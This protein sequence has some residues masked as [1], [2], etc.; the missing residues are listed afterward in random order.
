[1][2]KPRIAFFLPGL[3]IVNRGAENF[4]LELSKRLKKNYGITFLSKGRVSEN[5]ISVKGISRNNKMLCFI[6]KLPIIRTALKLFLLDPINIEWLTSSFNTFPK[7]FRTDFDLII[8]EAGMWGNLICRII[9]RF[10]HTPFVDVG[11]SRFGYW[12]YLCALQSPD[13]YVSLTHS[14]QKILKKRVKK[15]NSVV[16][17]GGVDLR[18]Y[19][20]DV[21]PVDLKLPKPIFLC[22]GALD[23]VK[24]THLA[25]HAVSK[26]KK[27]SL[28][29]LG[30]G[31]SRK[32]I[33][34]LG[35]RLLGKRFLLAA[36][37]SSQMPGY[38]AACDVFT[39]PSAR[40]SFGIIYA[41]AMAC[42]KPVVTT[43]DDIRMEIIGDAGI[44]C[45][46]ENIEEYSQALETAVH[47]NFGMRPRRQA[48]KHDWDGVAKKY[49]EL[50][51]SI[52]KREGYR[53]VL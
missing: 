23:P 43:R 5:W 24:R 11:H 48:E 9:R 34:E 49:D 46:C 1:M 22:V 13:V 7:L 19:N 20:P 47:K 25:I 38:Y 18:K 28:V 4:V 8:P 17:P 6:Y 44:L 12:E 41:E 15:I 33:Q 3:G 10:K 35:K 50:F 42:N 29:V 37:P 2:G 36:A 14:N 26:L 53:H 21:T 45:D 27:G 31:Q 16:I 39:L 51:R 32:K 52:I 40:E 30:E